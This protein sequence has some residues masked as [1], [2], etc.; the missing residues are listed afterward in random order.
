MDIEKSFVEKVADFLEHTLG[1]S[2]WWAGVLD[3]IL[4]V[5][6]L[7][8]IA[9][10]VGYAL[11]NWAVPLLHALVKKTENKW[12]DMLFD[13][14]VATY[15]S[16]IIP[17]YFVYRTLPLAFIGDSYWLYGLQKVFL[18]GLIALVICLIN[19]LINVVGNIIDGK[20]ALKDHP[21]QLIFQ[22]FKVIV[23]IIG[24]ICII[25]VL[26]NRS[27]TVLLTG[28][29][30]SAAIV[31]LVFKDTIVGFVSGV[32]LSA[33]GMVQKGDWISMPNMN[34]DG[35]VLEI[36]LHTVKVLNFDKSIVTIPPSTLLN[37]TFLNWRKMQKSGHRRICRD[38]RID[39]KSIHVCSADELKKLAAL[40][41]M[42]GVLTAIKKNGY[43]MPDGGVVSNLALFREFMMQYIQHHPYF[44]PHETFMVRQLPPT[45]L[46][47]PVQIYFFVKEVRWE[48]FENIQ[49]GV[50]DH[51]YASLPAF[52]LLPFQR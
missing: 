44:T 10:F 47:L 35:H 50:F 6:V 29:G 16:H 30:A 23:F 12:D 20:N 24:L 49:S 36:T 42:G 15:V 46:G 43:K 18:I 38:I 21:Y 2:A 45:E 31:S 25:S 52:G 11:K 8:L 28:L 37:S 14:R 34:V 48:P 3:S 27:P 19:A 39:V 7:L 13:S 51:V 1:L 40:P 41:Y 4:V 9:A 22:V 33:N 26:V 32:Q 5:A 17:V